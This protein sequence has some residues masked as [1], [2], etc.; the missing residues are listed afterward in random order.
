[1]SKTITISDKTW[2]KI[3]DQ[4]Q[5]EENNIKKQEEKKFKIK[6]R[7]TGEVI[8]SSSK[9]TCRDALEEAVSTGADLA[10]ADLRDAHLR[11]ANLRDADLRSADLEDANLEGANL[12]GAYLEGADLTDANLTDADFYYTKFYGKGGTTKI[13]KNQIDD[14]LK[15]LGVIVE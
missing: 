12:E 6:N 5:S 7:W 14:F 15:A 1:M 9:T 13:K 2:D 8:Y 3:K 11:D 10:G 4:V